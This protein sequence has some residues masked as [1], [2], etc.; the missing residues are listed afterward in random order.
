PPY[1]I[2]RQ[3]I[4]DTIKGRL[5]Q[6]LSGYLANRSSK[7]LGYSLPHLLR[8]YVVGRRW[9]RTC[10]QEFRSNYGDQPA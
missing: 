6:A 7:A 2:A 5:P 8:G 9:R 10:Y 1:M 4:A 3:L